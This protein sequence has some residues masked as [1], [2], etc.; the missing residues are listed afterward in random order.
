MRTAKCKASIRPNGSAFA[1]A[2][3]RTA[4]MRACWKRSPTRRDMRCIAMPKHGLRFPSILFRHAAQPARDATAQDNAPPSTAPSRQRQGLFR[5]LLPI[6][7]RR[8][9]DNPP[10]AGTQTGSPPRVTAA[11]PRLSRQAS[12][13]GETGSGRIDADALASNPDQRDAGWG[14][15][16]LRNARL[17]AARE[18]GGDATTAIQPHAGPT[19]E[20][21]AV[22]VPIP[23]TPAPAPVDAGTKPARGIAVLPL[24]RQTPSPPSV[25][26]TRAKASINRLPSGPKMDGISEP[27]TSLHRLNETILST[28]TEALGLGPLKA[29][30]LA[31]EAQIKQAGRRLLGSVIE[32]P[33]L[34]SAGT[35][36]N[37]PFYEGL[38]PGLRGQLG[39]A[40]SRADCVI[41][42]HTQLSKLGAPRHLLRV[43]FRASID[44][45]EYRLASQRGSPNYEAVAEVAQR[46]AEA[47]DPQY[48]TDQRQYGIEFVGARGRKGSSAEVFIEHFA[49]HAR[50]KPRQ[51]QSTPSTIND[52]NIRNADV[53][54]ALSPEQMNK[55]ARAAHV[56]HLSFKE[57]T[58]TTRDGTVRH[59]LYLFFGGSENLRRDYGQAAAS[60]VGR[61]GHV[62][63][64]A[65]KAAWIVA[66][67]V[68]QRQRDGHEV[69]FESIGG[70]SMGGASAQVFAAALQGSVKLVAPAAP[71]VLLDPQLLNDAQARHA[72][73]GGAH[74]YDFG[75]SRGVAITLDYPAAP[76]KSLMGRMKGLGYQSPGLVRIKLALQDDDSVKQLDNGEWVNRPPKPYGPP[77]TGYHGDLALYTKALLRFTSSPPPKQADAVP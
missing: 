69:R 57:E 68:E 42:E 73:K 66:Q 60:A 49:R 54:R 34:P 1:A 55:L 46:L 27:S 63:G 77:L 59:D 6:G 33:E 64:A 65:K 35:V 8:G 62:F 28:I 26:P 20:I 43:Q 67:A 24:N 18:A 74:D 3:S 31:R 10:G 58:S 14:I 36:K 48:R 40:T 29:T 16:F 72:T 4:G 9:A 47:I 21:E 56:S 51:I 2:G 70:V 41:S 53:F 52:A 61:V 45:G 32:K 71:L 76:R 25:S 17:N 15:R 12:R 11:S 5:G 19:P 39:L 22:P 23:P 37:L 13:A 44:R 7:K 50:V 30:A 75:G 38:V